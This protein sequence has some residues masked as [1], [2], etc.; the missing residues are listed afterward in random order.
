[1]LSRSRWPCGLRGRNAATRLLRLRVRIL[2]GHGC[3][4][5]VLWRVRGFCEELVTRPEESWRLWCVLHDLETCRRRRPW[6]GLGCSATGE[7]I[8]MI[9]GICYHVVLCGCE[10][11]SFTVRNTGWG[12]SVIGCWGRYLG[13]SGENHIMRSFIICA[14]HRMLLVIK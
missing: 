3:L 11:W 10:T 13:P 6:P 9:T 8:L 2:P 4:L 12:C 5:W 1:M 14:R 7:E